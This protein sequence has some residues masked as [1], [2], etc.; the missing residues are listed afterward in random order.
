ELIM[1]DCGHIQESEAARYN[2]KAARCGKPLIE[3][4]YKQSDV[5]PTT[6][7]FASLAHG[8][9]REIASGVEIRFTEAGHIIGSASMGFKIREKGK[10]HIVVF[11]GDI[12][13]SNMPLLPDPA[14][15][16]HAD[17]LF[18]EST[19]GDR[20]HRSIEDTVKELKD[21]F[22]RADKL[23]ARVLIPAFAV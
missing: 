8:K 22:R 10:E 16:D 18:M 2:R 4:L 7:L 17:L 13:R 21:L 1:M 5:E 20:D 19:Y 15:F 6:K 23:K 3:P 14:P 11:S 9:R 12:G